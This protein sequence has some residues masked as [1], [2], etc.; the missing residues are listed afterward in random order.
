MSETP[1]PASNASR[2][3]FVL[4]AGLL[5]G[6]VA[7]VMVVRAIQQ[8]QDPFPD[9]LMQVMAKQS[10]LLGQSQK[11]ARCTAEEV[12]PRLQTMRYLT[13]DLDHAFPGLR[14][15]SRFQGHAGKLRS[16]L[17]EALSNPPADCNALAELTQNI[18]SDCKA[19]HQDF[20]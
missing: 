5:V 19:C 6:I 10:Q 14:D 8:R 4:I 13:N 1:R 3:L 7:T 9:S 15:D 17:N 16:T 2:Y 11:Q 20:R 12:V 18:G